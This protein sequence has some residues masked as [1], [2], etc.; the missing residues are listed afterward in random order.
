M[1][2]HF[3]L[4]LE[5]GTAEFFDDHYVV[6]LR[7]DKNLIKRFLT[8]Q[9]EGNVTVPYK[10]IASIN[11]K[12][13]KKKPFEA[14]T[15][16]Y[17][18]IDMAPKNPVVDQYDEDAVIIHKYSYFLCWKDEQTNSEAKKVYE[19]LKQKIVSERG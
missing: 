15:G 2:T 11:F 7:K 16:N 14:L 9:V 4:N 13:Y 12:E 1:A 19:F 8:Y 3:K 18:A 10:N 5:G 17:G 6:I